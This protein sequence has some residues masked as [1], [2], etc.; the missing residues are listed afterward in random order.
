ME[1]ERVKCAQR[2]ARKFV[3]LAT[4]AKQ[5][6]PGPPTGEALERLREQ[7]QL[8]SRVLREMRSPSR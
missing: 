1:Y 4:E 8:L 7:S 3:K 6:W 5:A 2:E